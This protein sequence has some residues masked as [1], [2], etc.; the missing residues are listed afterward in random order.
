MKRT[1]PEK[2]KTALTWSVRIVR[3]ATAPLRRMSAMFGRSSGSTGSTDSVESNPPLYPS[4]TI[5]PSTGI[6]TSPRT[7]FASPTVSG[8]QSQPGHEEERNSGEASGRPSDASPVTSP[9][10]PPSPPEPGTEISPAKVRFMSLVRSA[11]MVNRLIGIGEEAKAKV[12]R[13]LTAG[14]AT[15]QKPEVATMPRSSRVAGLVPRLQNMAPSQDI[16]AHTAL[17]RHMQ[18]STKPLVTFVPVFDRP[19]QFSPDGKF[20]ATSSWDRTSV[21]F[22]VGVCLVGV[23]SRRITEPPFRNNS[24]PIRYCYTPPDLLAKLHGKCCYF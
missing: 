15:D 6:F 11:V 13:S 14:K 8:V 5:L 17:V 23:S 9:T 3:R 1:A 21:I 22:R 4:S 24:L 20:L 16:A 2:S 10:T 12:S 7:G 19:Y 18:V